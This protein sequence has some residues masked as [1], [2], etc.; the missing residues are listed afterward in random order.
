MIEIGLKIQKSQLRNACIRT[1]LTKA[2]A[3]RRSWTFA[4]SYAELQM[5]RG[6]L[7]PTRLV[8][9]PHFTAFAGDHDAEQPAACA[10]IRAVEHRP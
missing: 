9:K 8:A 6:F 10:K 7:P 4:A 3:R 5:G 2:A 1:S